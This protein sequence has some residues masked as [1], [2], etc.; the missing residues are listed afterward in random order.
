MKCLV[1]STLALIVFLA[2]AAPGL[3][4]ESSSGQIPAPAAKG[5]QQDPQDAAKKAAEAGLSALGGDDEDVAP[6][7]E[8]ER[9][10]RCLRAIRYLESMQKDGRLGFGE[11]AD[12]GVTAL[13][14]SAVVKTCARLGAERPAWVGEG[15]DYLLGLQHEDGSIYAHG[16]Q[17]YI[18]S[19]AV[20]AMV[21]AGDERFAEPVRRALAY[22][23]SGQ[24]DEDEGFS[25][26]NDP[27]YGGF[28]YGSPEHP[29]Q[30]AHDHPDMSNTQM[31]LQ[32]LHDSGLDQS[33]PAWAKAVQ[34]LARCQN[35]PETGTPPQETAD[36]KVIVPGDDGGGLYRPASS[37]AGLDPAGGN[38]FAARSY[39]S[40]TYALLKGY[41]FAGIDPSDERVKAAV[42]WIES[43][44]TLD[45]NPGFLPVVPTAKYQGLFYYYLTLSRALAAFGHEVITDSAGE[46]HAW[47]DELSSL[48][49]S[50]QAEDGHWINDRSTRWMEGNPVLTTSYALLT[51]CEVH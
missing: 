26:E 28:G 41:L 19:A 47:R 16:L 25:A 30:D 3:G 51:L 49:F 48:L 21:N 22:I 45:E 11:A 17:N 46:E 43:H 34:F 38:R 12:P 50:L 18:T 29:E 39:G 10:E 15:F 32:A 31:A 23:K 42:R 6:L 9:R 14:L 40:M 44:Y 1:A 36:G 37:K 20:E 2:G 13:A 35:L 33:D 5:V 24:F 7:T 8:A 27:Y 4:R